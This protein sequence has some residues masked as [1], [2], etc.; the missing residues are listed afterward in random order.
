MNSNV[1]I[2]HEDMSISEDPSHLPDG[3]S[4]PNFSLNK[5]NIILNRKLSNMLDASP[6]K[7]S[8]IGKIIQDRYQNHLGQPD[9]TKTLSHILN[10]TLIM[11][12]GRHPNKQL[13]EPLSSINRMPPTEIKMNQ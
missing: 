11:L 6:L 13:L 7:N 5:Q 3:I 1:I 8:F 2:G 4:K 12:K 9:G 10:E